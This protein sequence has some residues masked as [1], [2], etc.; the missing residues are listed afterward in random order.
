MGAQPVAGAFDLH[1]DGMVEQTVEECRGDDWVTEDLTPFGKASIAGQDHGA[2]FVAGIDELEE[3]VGTAVGDREV[4]DLVDD[5]EGSPAVEADL[6]DE[7]PL[8]FG[9]GQGAALGFD[10]FGEGAAIDALGR[11]GGRPY[12]MTPAKTRLA[13]AA[14]AKPGNNIGDLRKELSITCQTLYRFVGP[15]GELRDDAKA[16]LKRRRKRQS[17]TDQHL[18]AYSAVDK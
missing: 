5:Q 7:A 6:F 4:A 17:S 8:T 3:E 2:L 15:G 12:T 9:P 13:Q 16:L 18:L 11:K 14:M 10:Q 1:D